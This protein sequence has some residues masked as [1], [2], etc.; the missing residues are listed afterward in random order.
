MKLKWDETGE[1]L[2]ET[3]VDSCALY[4]YDNDAKAYGAGVA[5]NGISKVTE[6]PTGAE[7]KA[8]YADNIKYLNLFSAEEF[9]AT[10]NAYMYP[11]EFKQCDGSADLGTGVSIGQQARKTFGLAYKTILGNDTENNDYGYK[12]HIIYGC[13][14]QP[15]QKE[16]STV[17]DSPEA[18][19]FSW[20][21]KT[22]PDRKSVV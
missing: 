15:S 12:L 14:A 20:E 3:G 6:K 11:D 4:V 5:W 18:N 21:I 19:D 10:I 7:A 17:N 8:I 22:T 1:R 2:Y 16:Y 9:E 13:M